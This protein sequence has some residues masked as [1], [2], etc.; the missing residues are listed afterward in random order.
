MCALVC[1]CVG[2]GGRLQFSWFDFLSC[3]LRLQ[4]AAQGRDVTVVSCT[5]AQSVGFIAD[6]AGRCFISKNTAVAACL[7]DSLDAFSLPTL[8]GAG[9]KD[10]FCFTMNKLRNFIR[11]G[12]RPNAHLF[13]CSLLVSSLGPCESEDVHEVSPPAHMSGVGEAWQ[14]GVP[15]LL[16][17]L[18]TQPENEGGLGPLTEFSK[19]L[20][21]AGEES[22]C[23]MGCGEY[24]SSSC[25]K[26]EPTGETTP[27]GGAP[28]F[29]RQP[30]RDHALRYG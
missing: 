21:V 2:G 17:V 7:L 14:D 8:S 6:G 15:L 29:C 4:D 11:F 19:K 18:S 20:L 12:A 1:V 5:D 30:C 26:R 27:F 9:V 25:L 28:P 22:V 24:P 3:V 16:I 10:F 13:F 23:K